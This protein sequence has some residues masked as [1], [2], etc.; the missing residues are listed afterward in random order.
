MNFLK[1]KSLHICIQATIINP[2]EHT[3]EV[4]FS[5]KQFQKTY[6]LAPYLQP[7]FCR[8]EHPF[9]SWGQGVFFEGHQVKIQ[10]SLVEIPTPPA[11]FISCYG[12]LPTMQ[13]QSISSSIR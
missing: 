9:F 7:M 13:M 2:S 5:K 4:L 8:R 10:Y 1:V 3:N 12:S 11:A 6:K